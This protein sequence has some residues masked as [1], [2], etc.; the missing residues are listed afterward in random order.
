MLM[1]I[2]KRLSEG[3]IYSNKLMAKE[4]AVDESLVEQMITQLQHMGYIEKENMGNCSS[5]CDC[6]SSSKKGSCCSS[7]NNIEINIWK[8]TKKGK[9]AISN[10]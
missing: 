3:G 6:G 5:G 9:D 2:L 4:L 1:K 7:N 8:I 10:L